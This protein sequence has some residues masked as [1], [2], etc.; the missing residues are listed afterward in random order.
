MEVEADQSK[1]PLLCNVDTGAKGNVISL[2]TYMSLFPSSS[3]NPNGI[4]VNLASSS[5]TIVAFGGHPV[6]HNGICHLKLA[7]G[8]CCKCYPFHV[9]DA[10]G[11]TILG[12]PT[13]L[14]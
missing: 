10:E 1:K 8:S 11:P 2:N 14:P 9:V 5:S 4:P 3:C 7:H 13:W 12:L 6:D